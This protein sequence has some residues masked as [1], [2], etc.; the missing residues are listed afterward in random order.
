MKINKLKMLYKQIFNCDK[1]FGTPGCKMKFDRKK[2]HRKV[3]GRALES[4]V[5][6]LGQ[7]LRVR[8]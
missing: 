1:C 6:I 5:F 4:D 2:V 7:A 8:T 3:M